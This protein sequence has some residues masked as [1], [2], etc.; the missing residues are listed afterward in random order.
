MVKT[1]FKEELMDEGNGPLCALRGFCK[2]LRQGAR[3]CFLERR[4]PRRRTR[5]GGRDAAPPLPGHFLFNW[6][7]N[8][9]VVGK[10]GDIRICVAAAT[11]CS[12]SRGF[13]PTD[14]GL[15]FNPSRSDG[16]MPRDKNRRCATA[17]SPFLLP[18]VETHG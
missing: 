18:W 16:S 9:G 1:R 8:G 15:V 5:A 14:T 13:Q 17:D 12:V 4:R 3:D 2:R 6:S 7:Q 11:L 10:M